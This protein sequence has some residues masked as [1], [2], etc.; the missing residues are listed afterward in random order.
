MTKRREFIHQAAT[1]VAAIGAV[2][3]PLGS[4]MLP[5]AWRSATVSDDWDLSWTSRLKGKHKAVF[6]VPEIESGFGVYR[7]SSWAAQYADV[8]EAPPADLS[9]VIVLRGHAVVLGLQ[10]AFWDKY[11]VGRTVRATHPV[12]VSETTKNPV[13]LDERDRLPAPLANA[14]LHKQLGRGV[15]VLAC[16]VALQNWIDLIK[17]KRKVSEADARTE[18]IAALV[19]GVILQPSGVFAATLAQEH[20]CT[21]LRAS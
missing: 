1:G 20:G 5:P 9:P 4:N 2:T 18:A 19:P 10:Q 6:D 3:F 16:N 15:I 13:L 11:E 17:T 12:T 8:L 21:Y 7:A 14:A